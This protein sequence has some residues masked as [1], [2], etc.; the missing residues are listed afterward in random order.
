MIDYGHMTN[1]GV[2]IRVRREARGWKQYELARRA[3][4]SA[5]QLSLIENNRVS[6]SFHAVERLAHAFDTDLVGL[7]SGKEAGGGHPSSV[8]APPAL[9]DEGDYQTLR[10]IECDGAAALAAV[11][12][13]ERQADNAEHARGIVS[14]Y[15]L[16]AVS[17]G[18]PPAVT[19]AVLAEMLR[20]ELGLGTAPVGDLATTLA[21]R[22]VRLYRR[23]LPA[24]TA[25]VS[26]W[27]RL[28]QRPVI[29]L[30]ADNTRERDLYRLSYELGSIGLFRALGHVIDETLVQHRFLVDCAVSFLMPALSVRQAVAATGIGPGDWTLPKLVALKAYFGVSAEAF[31]LRLEELGLIAPAL[32]LEL[33]ERLHAYYHDHSDAKEPHPPAQPLTP[34]TIG[35][36][37]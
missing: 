25:S 5:A 24:A 28:A 13:A 35:E 32:R 16:G 2:L 30:N 37:E 1:L 8:A 19:G 27:R 6:P 17:P 14:P 34:A 18:V 31:A 3:E 22:G 9:P 11:L 4:M 26:F 10:S 36:E 29:V 15:T 7:L 12:D 33:R 21:F 23:A 20:R